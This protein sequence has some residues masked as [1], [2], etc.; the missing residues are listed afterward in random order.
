MTETDACAKTM[1]S[2]SPPPHEFKDSLPVRET[3]GGDQAEA[4]A[5]GRHEA[6]MEVKSEEDYTRTGG[7]GKFQ[8]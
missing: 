5:N 2:S 7:R 4:H 1:T 3:S 6:G 8:Y